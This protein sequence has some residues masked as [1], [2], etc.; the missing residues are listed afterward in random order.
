[1]KRLMLTRRTLQF[2]LAGLLASGLLALA[3]CGGSGDG[4]KNSYPDPAASITTTK[5]PNALIEPATLKQWMDEGK[6][7][8]ADPSTRDRVVIVTPATAAQ[9]AAQHLP[10]AQLL[11]SS[12][13]LL[14][15][16]LEGVGS[17]IHGHRRA[18]HGR[19]DP[20]DVH[21]PEHHCRL[22]RQQGPERPE[23]QPGLLHVPV[24]GFP[25]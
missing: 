24:L 3:G 20:A 21:R 22:R 17:M 2:G 25:A 12:S 19:P 13:E 4:G 23:C 8:S 7:N 9:Y 14:M 18:D 6:V 5:T 15:T 1:M 11:N 16:R 10:G